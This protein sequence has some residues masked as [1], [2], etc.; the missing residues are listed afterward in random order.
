MGASPARGMDGSIGMQDGCSPPPFKEKIAT[1]QV[2][3]V[4]GSRVQVNTTAAAAGDTDDAGRDSGGKRMPDGSG[5][6]GEDELYVAIARRRRGSDG[7]FAGWCRSCCG[8]RAL[9]AFSERGRSTL[10]VRAVWED[11]QPVE[12]RGVVVA[13]P[14]P[15]LFTQDGDGQVQGV[16]AGG[17]GQAREPQ[18]IC[19]AG[20]T[21]GDGVGLA[22][23][24]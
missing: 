22:A 15:I 24:P 1:Y 4:G 2:R 13:R 19:G 9:R 11:G 5:T 8:W 23:A 18:A 3:I 16:L 17:G 6:R 21:C 10:L 14:Y 20:R 7:I 12:L